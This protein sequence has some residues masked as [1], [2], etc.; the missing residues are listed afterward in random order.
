MLREALINLGLIA[1]LFLNVG[2][3]LYL[4]TVAVHSLILIQV[5]KYQTTSLLLFRGFPKV[6]ARSKRHAPRLNRFTEVRHSLRQS[7]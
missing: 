7:E 2:G 1:G 6:S 3:L 4:G 5:L